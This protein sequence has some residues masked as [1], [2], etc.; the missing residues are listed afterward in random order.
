MFCI[1]FSLTLDQIRNILQHLARAYKKDLCITFKFMLCE[2]YVACRAFHVITLSESMQFNVQIFATEP[3][4]LPRLAFSWTDFRN[5]EVQITDRVKHLTGDYG[6]CTQ[7]P[8]LWIFFYDSA[9]YHIR[10]KSTW[11]YIYSNTCLKNIQQ[12]SYKG[13]IL[14]DESLT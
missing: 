10:Y 6:T 3:N 4:G 1:P 5:N 11:I 2:S 7:I 8:S 14:S 12:S 13:C 9:S